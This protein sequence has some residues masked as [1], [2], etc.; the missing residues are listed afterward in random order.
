MSSE[1]TS[2][3]TVPGVDS[4]W[5]RL[6]WTLPAALLIWMVAL[7]GLAYFMEKPTH[8]AVEPP[9][10]NAQLIE[11]PAPVATQNTRPERPVAVHKPKPLPQVRPRQGPVMPQVSS[12]TE[13][14]PAAQQAGVPTNTGVSVLTA[15]PGGVPGEGQAAA[16]RNTSPDSGAQAGPYD[17]KGS[18]RGTIYANSGARAIVQPMP[19]I[20]D[21]LREEAFNFTALARFRIAVDGSAKVELAKPT[22]NP[23]LNWILLDSLKKWRFIPAI[24]NGKPVASIEEIVVKIEVK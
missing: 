6:P 13:Q 16:S 19:Q 3:R 10:I 18:P 4:P 1:T 20:P 2:V 9:P 24:K 12:P 23:R 21:D 17:R 7:W 11:Q 5:P 8:Q 14:R 22:P 15:P